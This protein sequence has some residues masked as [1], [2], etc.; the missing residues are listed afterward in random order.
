MKKKLF[1]IFKIIED[2]HEQVLNQ[3]K[4]YKFNQ[5][6]CLSLS[7]TFLHVGLVTLVQERKRTDWGQKGIRNFNFQLIVSF[8]IQVLLLNNF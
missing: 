1:I 3:M 2:L 6:L 4:L 8:K 5:D 7:K